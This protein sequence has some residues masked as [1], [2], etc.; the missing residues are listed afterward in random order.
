[1]KSTNIYG[2]IYF[3]YVIAKFFGFFSLSFK[4]GKVCTSTLDY[5]LFAYWFIFDILT[6]VCNI[7]VPSSYGP[8]DSVIYFVGAVLIV[9]FADVLQF[10]L[11]VLSFITRHDLAQVIQLLHS[12]DLKVRYLKIRIK[13]KIVI[14]FQFKSMN[15]IVDHRKHKIFAILFTF[16][17]TLG[18]LL[19]FLA[20]HFL[21]G[22]NA[23][24]QNIY[25]F[26]ESLSY[27]VTFNVVIINY[28]LL[29]CSIACRF[30]IIN[31]SLR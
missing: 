9:F 24:K 20:T 11:H 31:K 7:A 6:R 15:I 25:Y 10:C 30:K 4:D 26:F 27:N 14:Y 19:I 18:Q 12:V 22:V 1:M 2:V 8:T 3:N 28:F 21:F 5:I 13:F 16:W 29:V 23:F 17:A